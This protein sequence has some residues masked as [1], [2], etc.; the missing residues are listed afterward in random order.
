MK[1]GYQPQGVYLQALEPLRSQAAVAGL[2]VERRINR[3]ACASAAVGAV[4]RRANQVP[5]TFSSPR[6]LH[7][8]PQID[9][10]QGVFAAASQW[11]GK[12]A[13][14]CCL[15]GQLVAF[16]RIFHLSLQIS[17]ACSGSRRRFQSNAPRLPSR[18]QAARTDSPARNGITT[19]C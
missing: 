8:K 9:A 3:R 10:T 5:L 2:G 18:C 7:C 15:P 1:Q 16:L 19:H 17:S 11:L 14:P 13:P 12:P 4:T 6:A